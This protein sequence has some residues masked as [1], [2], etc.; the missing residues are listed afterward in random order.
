VEGGNSETTE[1]DAQHEDRNHHRKGELGRAER[2]AADPV[3]GRLQRHHREARQQ[4]DGSPGAQPGNR[5]REGRRRRVGGER[6]VMAIELPEAG[7]RDEV[8]ASHR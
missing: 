6:Q 1:C 4:C 5:L 2:E 3:E 7:R 8:Q